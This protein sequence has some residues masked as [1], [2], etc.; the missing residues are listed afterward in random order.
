MVLN[1]LH[2]A[3]FSC[4]CLFSIFFFQKNYFTNIIR[5]SDSLDPDQDRPSDGPDLSP[6]CLQRYSADEKSHRKQGELKNDF[7]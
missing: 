6:N 5:V 7:K 4:V 2:A 1:S 3:H